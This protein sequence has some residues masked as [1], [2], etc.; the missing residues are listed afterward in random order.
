MGNLTKSIF[1]SHCFET[2]CIPQKY[3]MI[4]IKKTHKHITNSTKT[5]FWKQLQQKTK[6]DDAVIF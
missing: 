4:L 3:Y 1:A 6:R 5:K 2:H